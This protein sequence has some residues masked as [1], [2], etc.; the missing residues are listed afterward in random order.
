MGHVHVVGEQEVG[1]FWGLTGPW[2]PLGPEP[3]VVRREWKGFRRVTFV[4]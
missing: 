1:W 3:F 2:D 4:A